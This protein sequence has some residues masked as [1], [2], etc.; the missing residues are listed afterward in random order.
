MRETLALLLVGGWSTLANEEPNFT[1]T[2]THS[3]NSD[4]DTTAD[5]GADKDAACV[6]ALDIYKHA[7]D[8]TY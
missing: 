3:T 2:T 5:A 7:K 4:V 8:D 6:F 1:D